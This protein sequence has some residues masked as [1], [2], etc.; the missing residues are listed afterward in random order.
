M[1]IVVFGGTGATGL[2]LV[3]KLL[4][5]GHEVYA[6]ARSPEKLYPMEHE[7]LATIEGTLDEREKIKE[8]V[9]DADA[10]ISLLGPNGRVKRQTLSEGVINIV[11]TMGEVGTK[12][13]L[14]VATSSVEDPKDEKSYRIN[15]FASALRIGLANN[16]REVERMAAAIRS[17]DLD[18]TLVRVGYL[19]DK[20]EKPVKVGYYGKEEVGVRVSRASLAQFM[21]DLAESDDYVKESPVVSN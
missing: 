17:T 20:G 16:Q 6:Y 12:R 1:K 5:R 2:R 3:D 14:G 15:A 19:N 4:G 18:W 21:A 8:T 11:E 9:R 13:F 10:V 7:R